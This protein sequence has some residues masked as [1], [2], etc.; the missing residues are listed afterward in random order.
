MTRRSFVRW[1]LRAAALLAGVGAW[2]YAVG[3]GGVSPLIL[4][5]IPSVAA[6]FVAAVAD[7]STWSNLAVTVGEFASSFAIATSLG[8]L[9]GFLGSRSRL[10]S[11]ALDPM[12]SWGYM[13]PI[14]LLFPVFTLWFGV[15]VMSKILFASLAG[16]FPIAINTLKGLANV[17]EGYVR[18][19][20]AFGATPL[21]LE[22]DV[23][24]PAGAPLVLSGIRIG[25]ALA[26]INVILGEMLSSESGLGYKLAEASQTLDSARALALILILIILV[27]VPQA[28]LTRLTDR[29]RWNRR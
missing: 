13:A 24:L 11:L 14:E 19:G 3:P 29:Q 20:R 18:T 10:R 2:E 8:V 9:V 1:T 27:T 26:M 25:A 28:A 16:F 12:L 23:K 21:Q 17:R 6:Q 5:T 15:G 22:Y 4:P 7:P